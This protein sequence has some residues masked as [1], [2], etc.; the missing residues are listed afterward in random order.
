MHKGEG[1]KK[2]PHRHKIG[3]QLFGTSGLQKNNGHERV[4]PGSKPSPHSV[5]D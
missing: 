5:D 1:G 4:W 2:K 3:S